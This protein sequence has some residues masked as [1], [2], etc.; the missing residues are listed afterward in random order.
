[1]KKIILFQILFSLLFLWMGCK[2]DPFDNKTVIEGYVL[3]Y[4]SEKPLPGVAIY[5]KKVEGELLGPTYWITLDTIFTD[6]DGY[7]YYEYNH[8]NMTI[9]ACV[10]STPDGY[11][12]IDL[13]SINTR[14]LNDISRL[15]DPYAHL[16]LHIKNINPVS[17]S[18]RIRFAYQFGG[19]SGWQEL[20][21]EAVDEVFDWTV[22][23]NF[24]SYILWKVTKN[25]NTLEYSDTLYCSAHDTTFY[26]IF[27]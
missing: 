17:Q 10:F 26:E 16:N 13:V 25:N 27:Y 23:G 11:Y 20:Y 19:P 21:G 18:D 15:V 2:K 6:S 8:N 1:M 3:E 4:G 5:L 22:R 12:P 9:D 24:P 7:V 14:R